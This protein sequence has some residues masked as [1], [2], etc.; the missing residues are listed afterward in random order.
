MPPELVTIIMASV[1]CAAFCL[2]ILMLVVL[3]YRKDPLCCR[4]RSYRTQD[5]TD[6]L[7]HYHSRHSLI[8]ISHDGH[9][10]A[11]NQR[12]IGPQLPGALFIIG[13]PRDYH[14]D[15]PPPRLPSYES[16]RKKDRQ[17][18]I[19]SMIAQRFGLSGC[20]EEPPPTYEETFR[21]SLEILP[22]DIH[23]SLDVQLP[24]SAYDDPPNLSED[25][26]NP[27]EGCTPPQGSASPLHP[28]PRC[29][30]LSI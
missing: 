26:H 17:R 21:H 2:A 27:G 29:K 25:Q 8:G 20:P 13:K 5:Y 1:S 7:P 22:A 10:A 30:F 24:V 14:M 16:V 4:F 12:A 3:L 19:H 28:A 11:F 9:D 6:H 15:G 18:P 23:Q